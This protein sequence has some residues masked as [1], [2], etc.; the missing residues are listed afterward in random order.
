M[1]PSLFKARNR[2]KKVP[3]NR[4]S[5]LICIL[6]IR[7]RLFLGTLFLFFAFVICVFG[8]FSSIANRL[9]LLFNL[10]SKKPHTWIPRC[11][12]K[13]E[14]IRTYKWTEIYPYL[15]KVVVLLAFGFTVDSDQMN[16][17][18]RRS[19]KRKMKIKQQQQL[20]I[21]RQTHTYN[22]TTYLGCET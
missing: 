19:Q 11:N 10:R 14:N 17:I 16:A 1:W 15:G 20:S 3:T 18:K 5:I 12:G 13:C 4:L 7:I 6:C 9:P 2:Q 8:L 22:H 21:L